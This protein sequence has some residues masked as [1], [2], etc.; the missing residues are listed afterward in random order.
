MFKF[1]PKRLKRREIHNFQLL[2][3][4]FRLDTSLHSFHLVSINY[5]A[6]GTFRHVDTEMTTVELSG[7][8]FNLKNLDDFNGKYHKVETEGSVT[9]GG[10][11]VTIKNQNG[12]VV[13]VV[14]PIEGRKFDLTRE[15]LD[16]E[17][18]K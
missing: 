15:G 4:T 1:Q 2:G 10:S 7:Q 6:G 12:V 3:P 9:G 13:N 16:V 8:V 11:R 14:S 18:K 17:L 5:R